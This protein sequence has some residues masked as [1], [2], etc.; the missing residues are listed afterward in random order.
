MLKTQELTNIS[1]NNPIFGESNLSYKKNP[2]K[3]NSYQSPKMGSI[4]PRVNIINS[5][6]K[7][8]VNDLNNKPP[9]LLDIKLKT[10]SRG[11][12]FN[13]QYGKPGKT[14]SQ[15]FKI[16]SDANH[17]NT[18]GN[19]HNNNDKD[20]TLQNFNAQTKRGMLKTAVVKTRSTSLFNQPDF[21]RELHYNG[22]TPKSK[23]F[24]SIALREQERLLYVQCE[25][26]KL[27]LKEIALQFRK[28]DV[29]CQQPNNPSE[30][31][32]KRTCS[33]SQNIKTDYSDSDIFCIKN[34]KTSLAKSSEKL[35]IDP[36]KYS[37]GTLSGS[38]WYPKTAKSTLL[39]YESSDLNI[40]N[41]GVRG[42]LKSK[43]QMLAID[44]TLSANKKK[45]VNEYVDLFRHF[46]PNPNVKYLNAY[47]KNKEEFKLNSNLCSNLLICISYIKVSPSLLTK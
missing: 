29:F 23:E 35:V 41:L 8:K 17:T 30:N 34:N 7:N 37:T 46:A 1:K 9:S 36:P 44:P 32:P 40:L 6:Y 39:N 33:A 5:Q 25:Q 12:V 45:S 26:P 10:Y 21:Q 19:N 13:K 38:N 22:P 31:S 27:N 18:E 24:V 42:F 11:P 16:K 47:N 43:E 2:N 28:S 20:Q 14:I 4:K 15:L 3:R